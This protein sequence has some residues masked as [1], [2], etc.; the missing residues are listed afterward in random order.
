MNA[1]LWFFSGGGIFTPL[2]LSPIAWWDNGTPYMAV[3]GSSWTDRISSKVVSLVNSSVTYTPNAQNGK[4][5]MAF[6]GT[7]GLQGTKIAA[8]EGISGI[9]LWSVGKRYAIQQGDTTNGWLNMIGQVHYNDDTNYCVASDGTAKY[10]SILK[11]NVFNYSVMV[12]DGTQTGNANRL[13]YWVNGVQQTLTF[14][15]TIPALTQS[16]S[17]NLRIG[18]AGSL[19]VSGQS[20]E[21]GIV[22]RAITSVEVSSLNSYLSTKY[23]L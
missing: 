13:K 9:T 12:F 4:P 21:H 14:T 5:S 16:A 6:A 18:Q 3:D 20:L 19:A 17:V 10:G 1:K 11:S 22:S 15:G 23:A 8:I 7:G 2:T